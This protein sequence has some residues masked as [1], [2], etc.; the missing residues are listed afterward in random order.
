MDT[1]ICSMCGLEKPL[2]RF[3]KNKSKKS[4]YA[5]YCKDCHKLTCHKYYLKNK[6][7][8][9]DKN[10][11]YKEYIKKYILDKKKNGCCICGEKDPACLDFHHLKDKEANI[12]DLIKN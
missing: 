9:L 1:K 12:S 6:D 3:V 5:S 2:K 10:G 8:I 4:G 11:K 7:K